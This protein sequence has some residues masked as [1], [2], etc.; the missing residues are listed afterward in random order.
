[1]NT[2]NIDY[3]TKMNNF[4]K[5][6]DD[7]EKELEQNKTYL[8]NKKNKEEQLGVEMLEIE[9]QYTKAKNEYETSI[10]EDKKRKE[11]EKMR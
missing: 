10:K 2:T 6:K 4:N 5:E 7:L 1:M 11:R 3:K 9:E 8:E